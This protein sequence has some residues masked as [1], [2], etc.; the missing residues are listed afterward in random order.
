MLPI[1]SLSQFPA[2]ATRTSK[3]RV[4]WTELQRDRRKYIKS[5]YLPK[6]VA[7]KQFHHLHQEDVNAILGHWTQRQADGK[8]PFLFREVA[9]AAPK[10]QRTREGSD[11][12]ADVGPGEGDEDRQGDDGSQTQGGPL[13]AGTGSDG[14]TEQ[15]HPSQSLSNAAENP[16]QVRRL[17]EHGKQALNSLSFQGPC[18]SPENG[19]AQP[20]AASAQQIGGGAALDSPHARPPHAPSPRRS[21]SHP[22]S[23]SPRAGQTEGPNSEDRQNDPGPAGQGPSPNDEVSN[24]D[25][26]VEP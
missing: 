23:D 1:Q 11:A 16:N 9:K 24:V 25:R 26:L 5:K 8:V 7:L 4:P 6:D 10:N 17:R 22:L 20:S 2:I 12:D 19:A 15:A 3:G 13:Q 14:S 21:L 18:H